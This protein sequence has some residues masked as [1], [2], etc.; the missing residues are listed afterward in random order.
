[1]VAMVGAGL[2]YPNAGTRREFHAVR[3]DI[4][5]FPF[6]CNIVIK[7]DGGVC[8]LD[9]LR[10]SY[11]YLGTCIELQ[12]SARTPLKFEIESLSGNDKR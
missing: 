12:Y 4:Y 6:S 1:M 11:M 8:L 7:I 2:G 5:Q 10:V 9:L 3:T